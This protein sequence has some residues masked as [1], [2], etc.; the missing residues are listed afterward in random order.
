VVVGWLSRVVLTLA[1]LGVL[2]FD[3]T[4]LLIGRV[5]VS[6][7]A[8]TAAQAAA[9]DWHQEHSYAAAL[10]AAQTSATNDE[11]VPNTLRINPDGSAVLSLHREVSTLVVRHLP[12]LK[13]VASVTESGTAGPPLS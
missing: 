10:L 6:G 7:D 11:V 2:L 4:A 3:T 8:D 13:E 1:V 9:A 12:R 5:S